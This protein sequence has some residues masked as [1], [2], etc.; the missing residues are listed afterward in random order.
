MEYI[1]IHSHINLKEFDSNREQVLKDAEDIGVLAILDSGETFE[2]NQKV[3]ELAE[4]YSI[5]KPSLGFHPVNLD[6]EKAEKVEKQIREN[7]EKTVAIGEIGLDYWKVQDKTDQETQRN[8]FKRFI[9]LAKELD[10][11]IITHSRSAGK[12]V[13]QML[14]DSDAKRV[15]MHAFD[16]KY[17]TAKPGVEAGFYFSIPP[18]IIRSNQKQKLVKE[19]PLESIILETDAPVLGPN[20]EDGNLPANIC[21]SA[22]VIAN[23]K[24]TSLEQVCEITTKNAK[25]LLGNL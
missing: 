10:K 15:N 24:H 5:L 19:L 17:A 12:D 22:Q 9:S 20:K 14:I 21:I 18:S 2:E 4:Q 3:L 7:A 16:G 6:G 13:I 23:I 25:T 11:P 8:N 1:D